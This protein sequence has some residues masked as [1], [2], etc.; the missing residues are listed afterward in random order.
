MMKHLSAIVAGLFLFF[1][2]ACLTSQ[3][4]MDL[5]DGLMFLFGAW[6]LISK[7]R[8]AR[9]WKMLWPKTTGLGWLWL[10]WIVVVAAG[11]FINNPVNQD[12]VEALLEFRWMLIFHVLCFTLAWI[13]WDS[14]KIQAMLGFLVVM[15]LAS[16][17]M[18][19]YNTGDFRAGGPFGHSMPFAHSYGAAVVFAVGLLLIGLKNNMPWKWLS[20]VTS[21]L[22]A[23]IIALSMTRGVWVGMFVGVLAIS[24]F[25]SRVYG[26]I[27]TIGLV[28]IFSLTMVF[29]PDARERAFSTASEQNVGDNQRKD[30]WRGNIE[31]AKDYPILGSGYSQNKKLLRYYYDQLGIPQGALISHA[32]NQ[33][34]HF[35][36]GTGTLGLICYLIFLFRIIQLTLLAF[37]RLRPELTALKA[38]TLGA[39]GGQLC[40]IVGSLTESNFSIAK[41]RYMFLALCS[42]GVSIYYRFVAKADFE[43]Y[44]SVSSPERTP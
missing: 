21:V 36:A 6:L 3:S 4:L 41:N 44:L 35:L 13:E 18:F 34:L 31:I 43:R 42:I 26:T 28:T 25:R 20:I 32:H 38:L 23:V 12:T 27:A 22:G 14:R 39:L 11:L 19:H 37:V 40:F 24:C 5:A 2:F 16:F 7:A 17:V 33:Y 9:D 8:A 10:V 1:W 29:S 15:V 30:I